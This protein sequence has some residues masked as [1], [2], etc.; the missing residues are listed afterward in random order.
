M[1]I[2]LHY[3]YKEY[4]LSEELTAKSK[5]VASLTHPL[6]CIV[7][8]CSLG[9]LPGFIFS[10]LF[11]S[12][13]VIPTMLCITGIM[14][15][16]VLLFLYREKK[17]AEYDAEYEALLTQIQESGMSILEYFFEQAKSQLPATALEFCEKNANN[18]PALETYLENITNAGLITERNYQF[19]LKGYQAEQRKDSLNHTK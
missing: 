14:V 5:R 1:R 8:G 18:L 12:S 16:P 3:K 10:M 19:L 7:L 17:F 15:G 9:I 6:C 13:L 4:P 11:P 2:Y